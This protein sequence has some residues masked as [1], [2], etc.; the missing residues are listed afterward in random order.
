MG[1]LAK[2]AGKAPK[3]IVAPL[4]PTHEAIVAEGGEQAHG[5]NDIELHI[6]TGS[7][8]V[9]E[10]PSQDNEQIEHENA[11][12][13]TDMRVMHADEQV[14]QV[15]LVGMEGGAATK[16]TDAHDTYGIE[17]GDRKHGEREGHKP[18]TPRLVKD[19][20]GIV[21]QHIEHENTHDDT[22]DKGTSITDKHLG[23]AAKH[24]MKKEGYQRSDTHTGQQHHGYVARDIEVEAENTASHD[25]VAAA[26]TVD[27]I[28]E[29]DRIDEPHHSDNSE[30]DRNKSRHGMEPP[31]TM[32]MV[33]AIT[34]AIHQHEGDS[35]LDEE[36]D[37]GRE[38]HD[39]VDGT[40]I[41]HDNHGEDNAEKIATIDINM[42]RTESHQD[43]EH[44][45]HT[46]QNGDRHTLQLAGIGIVD[47]V[48]FQS[49]MQNLGEDPNRSQQ[50]YHKGYEDMEGNRHMLE[51]QVLFTT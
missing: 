9:T 28:D 42:T 29:I 23:G 31:Q 8:L 3:G 5:Q 2:A 10:V 15:G 44:H 50:G 25:A 24:I 6:D 11:Q 18:H 36:T 34:T 39:I 26:I 30:R 27:T 43:T 48:F 4:A 20:A 45:S 21:L 49:D 51:L 46:T 7:E 22:H 13:S 47:N 12:R 37:T 1:R 32:E 40:H 16:D 19:A 35:Y 33:D 14:V 38:I 41:E 17:Y